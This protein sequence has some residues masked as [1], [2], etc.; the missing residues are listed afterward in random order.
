MRVTVSRV[1]VKLWF[2]PILLVLSFFLASPSAAD[3]FEERWESATSGTFTPSAL[4][5]SDGGTWIL[6]D[7]VSEFPED[8]GAT[9][10]RAQILSSGGSKALKLISNDSNSSCSDNV[11]I[12]LEEVPEFNL[13]IG[14]SIPLESDSLIAFKHSGALVDP[15]SGSNNC[16]VLPCGDTISLMLSDKRGNVIAYILNRAPDAVPNTKHSNYRE[17]FLDPSEGEYVRNLFDDFSTIPAFTP[18]GA[19]IKSI[20]YKIQDHGWGII[21]DILVTTD[22]SIKPLVADFTANPTSGKPPLDVQFTDTS[23]GDITSWLWDFGDG[24]SSTL[25]DPVHTYSNAGKY[26]VSLTVTGPKG[27][28]TETKNDYISVESILGLEELK[29]RPT[30]VVAGD[31]LGNSVSISGDYAIIGAYFDDDKGTN[32]GSAYIYQRIGEKWVKAAKLSASDGAA[33]DLFG[34]NVS[35]S[36]RYAIVSAFRDDDNG[37]ESGSAYIFQRTGSKWN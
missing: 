30:D 16:L 20:E 37:T 28:E 32:S 19:A 5:A 6:T 18:V 15:Q 11:W 21:D 36:G 23:K 31:W 3:D 26:T 8:C 34:Y 17:I 9:P 22:P 27:S 4:I 29:V 13:N 10:H 33:N 12:V 7:T 25:Q 35:I 14:F 1:H 24:A 2:I